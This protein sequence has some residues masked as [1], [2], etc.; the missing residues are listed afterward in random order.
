VAREYDLEELQ[1]SPKPAEEREFSFEELTG[2]RETPRQPRPQ[3]EPKRQLK[4][5]EIFADSGKLPETGIG[6][7]FFRGAQLSPQRAGAAFSQFIPSKREEATR[8]AQEI[9]AELSASTPKRVGAT[10]AD[11]V[12]LGK[13]ASPL[14]KGGTALSR[15]LKAGGVGGGITAATTPVEKDVN[16]P[17]FIAEKIKQ[18]AIGFGFGVVPQ[19]GIEGVRKFL[20]P[21]SM[22]TANDA[23]KK[24][25]DEAV[26]RGYTLPIS[27]I[28]D[29]AALQTLDRLFDSP[30][31][32]RNAPVFARTINKLMGETSDEISPD[33]MAKV[34]TKLSNEIET[35]VRG[36]QIDMNQLN[37]Q[38]Q[39]IL[40]STLQAIPEVEPTKLQRIIL[41]LQERAGANRVIDGKTW[42]ET[43]QLLQKEAMRLGTDPAAQI[44]KDLVK[45]WDNAAFNSIKDP[46][47]KGAFSNWKGKYTV[48]S[49]VDEAVNA[50]STARSNYVKGVLDPED[51]R[52]T[53]ASKRPTEFTR[54]M[55]GALGVPGGGRAQTTE[56]GV[57][58]GL[59]VFGRQPEATAPYYRAATAPKVLGTLL[60]AKGLQEYLYSPA[61]QRALMQG[62]Q[63]EQARYLT[64]L[65]QPFATDISRAVARQASEE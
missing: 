50:N 39:Q 53:I 49:D 27:E 47:W 45:A 20:F 21:G 37:P 8:R 13:L 2:T 16:T 6:G 32:Q 54:R 29:S 48:F 9:E 11:I 55:Y 28:T 41:S 15:T 5:S 25:V 34:S 64:S 17:D 10:V 33:T 62:L 51:L 46:A 52:N 63:P 59:N 31:V 18:G 3:A 60:G 14:I 1:D 24:A 44:A 57:I 43:R 58:G 26:K 22:L 7:E 4:F 56:A 19:A 42:H 38:A 40:L 61:G 36:K 65:T 30:L 12:G 35:L 23:T